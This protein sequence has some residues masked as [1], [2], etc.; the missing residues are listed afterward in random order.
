MFT[1]IFDIVAVA[2]ASCDDNYITNKTVSEY[3]QVF[4]TKFVLDQF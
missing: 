3:S 2:I 4:L 1:A